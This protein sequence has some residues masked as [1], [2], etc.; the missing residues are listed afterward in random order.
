MVL[1]LA[2]VAWSASTHIDGSMTVQ[3]ADREAAIQRVVASAKASGGWF[4]ALSDDAVTIQVPV[5]QAVGVLDAGKAL[6]LVVDRGWAVQELD[7]ELTDLGARL[8]S[9][10]AVLK[11]Y[12][13]ILSTTNAASVVAVEREITRTVTEIE[14]IKGRTR[15]LETRSAYANLAFSFRFSDRA[16]PARDGRSSFAW[17]NGLNLADLQDAFRSGRL[18]HRSCGVYAVAP[19]GFAAGRRA[20]RFNAVSPDDVVMRVRR[21]KNRPRA[22]LAFWKEAMRTR[23]TEAGYR[24][25][26]EGEASAGEARGA[27]LEL[28]A[29]DGAQDAAYLVVVFV[30]GRRLVVVEAAGEVGRFAKRREAI[31]GAIGEL[32]F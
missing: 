29:P 22:D 8:A 3:V 25:V 7:T 16:A 4:S 14:Q 20:R 27:L 23:M 1:L 18:S 31:L 24:V 21:A 15:Y 11:R 12:L 19:D 9:R 2:G 17:L 30:D 5:S 6:G 28:S 32:R 26:A 10:E 13:D